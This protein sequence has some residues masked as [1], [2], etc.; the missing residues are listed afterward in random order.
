MFDIVL[1]AFIRELNDNKLRKEATR[2]I[3][4]SDRSLKSI[5]NLTEET[6]RTNIKIQKLFDEKHKHDKLQ[7]YKALAQKNL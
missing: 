4:A 5:Y 1:R 2:G 3:T 7:Y 6:R